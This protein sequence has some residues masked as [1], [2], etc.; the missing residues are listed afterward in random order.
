VSEQTNLN[1]EVPGL[2]SSI[3]ISRASATGVFYLL[4]KIENVLIFDSSQF[5]LSFYAR[6]DVSG[7]I[8][9]NLE[10][11]FGS[12]GSATIPSATQNHSVVSG[13]PFTRFS[14]TFDTGSLASFTVGNDSFLQVTFEIPAGMTLLQITGVQLEPGPVATPFEHRPIQT[15]L[16]LCQRYYEEYSSPSNVTTIFRGIAMAPTAGP[17]DN[18][19]TSS[20]LKFAT[21]KRASPTVTVYGYD[22]GSGFPANE[23]HRQDTTS[24]T[25]APVGSYET[26]ETGVNII[27]TGCAPTV[28]YNILVFRYT[29]DA[30][31]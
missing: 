20:T 31:L 12:G 13:E 27:V 29:A 6:A 8:R 11:N 23:V 14:A 19:A 18:L 10:Y 25:N 3:N 30:E 7:T 5:T 4:Q 2:S 1:G 15:E 28:Y 16:A 17:P 24:G 9:T 22:T 26:S 21:P